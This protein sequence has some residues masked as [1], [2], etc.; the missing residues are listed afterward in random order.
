MT[1]V[2]S[3][4]ASDEHVLA[5]LRG[6]KMHLSPAL[7]KVAEYVIHEPQKVIHQTLVDVAEGSGASEASVVRFCRD[8]GYSSFSA[9]KIDLSISLL[10]E[11]PQEKGSDD[12]SIRS[13]LL[14]TV[15]SLNDTATLL[16]RALLDR[17]V[18]LLAKADTIYLF[19]VGASATIATY[20]EY[21]MTRLGMKTRALNDMHSALMTVSCMSHKDVIVLIS[22]SGKTQDILHTA[23][24]ARDQGCDI[25]AITGNTQS[26]LANTATVALQTAVSESVFSAGAFYSKA[27]Q[28][29]MIDLIANGILGKYPRLKESVS[30]TAESVA[31]IQ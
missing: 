8:A 31:F 11:A 17:T 28:M 5:R 9:F 7:M 27:A 2:V 18:E 12:D 19:G 29:F 20:G 30:K 25:V 4:I 14:K 26:E 23:A 24:K 22:G 10:K 21:R 13:S 1:S 6:R 16:D 15:S 3:P